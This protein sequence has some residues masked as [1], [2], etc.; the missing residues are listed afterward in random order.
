MSD[1]TFIRWF[2]IKRWFDERFGD[3]C[4]AHDEAYLLR[5][6]KEKVAS[7]FILSA[8]MASRKYYLLAY[9]TLLFMAIFGTLYWGWKKWKP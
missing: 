3:L 5:I 4:K 7:D 1:C 2:G 6:W 9:A 8:G